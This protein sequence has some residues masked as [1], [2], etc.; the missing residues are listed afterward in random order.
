MIKRILVWLVLIIL[1][2]WDLGPIY[3]TFRTSLS[4]PID[5]SSI[6]PHYLPWPSTLDNYGRLFGFL[7]AN[8]GSDVSI[9]PTIQRALINSIV[10]C[11]GT[12]IAVT[13]IAVAAGYVFAR[14]R[15]V[16]GN[17]TFGLVIATLALPAYAVIIPLYRMM[18][19]ANLINT[20]TCL[21]LIYASA[22]IPLAIWLMRAYFATIPRELDEAA[23]IDGASRIR[24]ILTVLPSAL[25]GVVATAIITFL[26][27]W[28]QFA[29]P[30]VFA[31]TI[32][33]QPLTV[34]IANFVG[35][36]TIDYGLMTAA[37]ML[38][39]LPPL[40]IVVF[41]NRYLVS[42]LSVGAVVE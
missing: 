36:T 17:L 37:S 40:V 8:T 2:V 13:V 39:I 9:W 7:P 21:I 14:L 41:L 11:V 42:G 38:T 20:Y 10:T 6:P 1:V 5:L 16:G 28:S 24:V 22:F 35:K 26:S 33:S 32:D 4:R 31:P 25:P 29:I 19:Q 12:T 3:W 30:L 27:A 15:F 18:V 34:V 23:L